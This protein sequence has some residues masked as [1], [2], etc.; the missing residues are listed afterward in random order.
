[1]PGGT[2]R[3]AREK[4]VD[5]LLPGLA[6][7][8]G[9]PFGVW[10][11][12][13][14]YVGFDAPCPSARGRQYQGAGTRPDRSFDQPGQSPRL[15]QEA[16]HGLRRE[17]ARRAALRCALSR[18]RQLQGCERHARPRD[19]RPAVEGGRWQTASCG[20]DRGPGGAVRRRRVRHSS[21]AV[22]DPETAG[23]LAAR[24]GKL[25]AV[26]C[27]IKGHKVR[28]TSSIGIA[29]FSPEPPVPRRS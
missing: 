5:Q 12:A 14:L 24:I 11:V 2:C 23:E 6:R 8:C 13:R 10:R 3:R 1:M 26:P 25:L 27:S 28:I 4:R 19:G 21:P 20:Q 22:T 7:A 9:R 15:P 18:H 29:L 16:H 17:L